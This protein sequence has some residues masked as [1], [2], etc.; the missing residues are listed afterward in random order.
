MIH[1]WVLQEKENHQKDLK[2][3][4]GSYT[5]GTSTGESGNLS[6]LGLRDWGICR[7]K[8]CL[9]SS[10]GRGQ[11]L[12]T[13]VQALLLF[14]QEASLPHCFRGLAGREAQLLAEGLYPVLRARQL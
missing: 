2:T 10:W 13:L 3:P 9:V 12:C 7:H 8:S 4:I 14:R 1:W 11:Q 5:V 6:C